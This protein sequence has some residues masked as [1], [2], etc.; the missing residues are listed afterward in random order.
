MTSYNLG[1]LKLIEESLR[2][3]MIEKERRR[4]LKSNEKKK[5]IETARLLDAA[6][7]DARLRLKKGEYKDAIV[8]FTKVY[9]YILL[10]SSVGVHIAF[11][12]EISDRP[13]KCCSYF[14]CLKSMLSIFFP[15][16]ALSSI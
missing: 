12:L 4:S 7:E 15:I 11:E 6:L 13:E 5:K 2:M 8:W 16:L 14:M 3:E 1:N 9:L 10:N